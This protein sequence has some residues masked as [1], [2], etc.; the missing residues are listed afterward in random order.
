M[1]FRRNAIDGSFYGSSCATVA[2]ARLNLKLTNTG[3]RP[4]F[5]ASISVVIK[6]TWRFKDLPQESEFSRPESGRL[7][8]G[9][10]SKL[11]S[12][13]ASNFWLYVIDK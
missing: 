2:G 1:V 3:S 4:A 9:A 11:G 13:I 8:S 5:V 10:Q 6:R 7:A 12:L